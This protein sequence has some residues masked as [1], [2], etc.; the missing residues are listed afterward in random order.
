MVFFIRFKKFSKQTLNIAIRA[1]MRI[2]SV[3][4]TLTLCFLSLLTGAVL[5]QTSHESLELGA[6]FEKNCSSCHGPETQTAGINLTSLTQEQPLVK[7]IEIW[8]RVIGALDVGKMPPP[9]APQPSVS[10][11]NRMLELLRDDIE[12]YDFSLLD[13][14]GFELMRRLTHTEYD[15]T[16]RDL[17]GVE[18]NVTERFPTELIGNSGFENSSNTLF[19]QPA[20]M[21]R[22][23][24]AAQTVVDLALPDVPDTAQHFKTREMIFKVNPTGNANDGFD[25]RYVLSNFLTRAYRRPVTEEELLRAAEQYLEAIELGLSVEA[26]IKQVIQSTLI[27][28]KFLLRVEAGRQE[29]AAYRVSDWE[30]ASRLSYFL[31]ATMPDEELFELAEAGRLSDPVVL[32]KQVSRMLMDEKAVT[33]GDVF[34]A[35]WLGFHNVGTRIWLDPIDNPWCTDTLMAAMRDETSM[36]FMSLIKENLPIRT[37]IDADFTYVNEELASILYGID[38]VS[39]DQ[40]RRIEL[41]DPNRGGILG[42][43]SILALTSNYKTTSPVKR[44]VYVLDTIL[45][46]PPPEPPPNVGVLSQELQEMQEMSFREKVEMHSSNEY[47][48]GC[49]SRI[50]PIGFSMENFSYFGQWRDT[51]DF[52][53][54]V[55]SEEEADE[56]ITI[57]T[58]SSPE[59]LTIHYKTTKRPIAAQGSLPDGEGFEGPV[60]LKETLLRDRHPDLVRQVVTKMLAYSL[61]RQLEYYDE[62]AIREI[63]GSL[64]ED[65]YKFQTLIQK[66]VASYPFQYKKNPAEEIH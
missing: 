35:Q 22:Y 54:R 52:R 50:D 13:D 7:N 23:I 58:E 62:P 27:S 63:M 39:G 12:N 20:L 51:Y 30:L 31:W 66:V 44:G 37:L 41:K 33:L 43:A 21:E 1:K 17:F 26:A 25:S 42:H 48:R 10:E 9:G 61:G 65:D 47:C 59:P 36:F 64:E 29:S 14:P 18:L 45:G 32:E 11:R 34:A 53:V 28:P 2:H 15:N 60:G 49:H 6:L 8:R 55:D 16:I 46:T 57:N 40:M 56:S 5:G 19:L 38:D 4:Q 3:F 24:G